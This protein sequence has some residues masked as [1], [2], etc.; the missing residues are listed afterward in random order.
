MA[1]PFTFVHAADLHLGTPFTGMGEVSPAFSAILRDATLAA[2]DNL[3]RLCLNEEAAFL[4]I[5]GDVWDGPGRSIRALS[6]FNEGVRKLGERGIPVF[7]S[8]GNHDPLGGRGWAAA[9]EMPPNLTVFPARKPTAVE[10]RRDGKLLAVVHG[11]SYHK[12]AV[13]DDLAARISRKNPDGFEVG[14][15]HATV[16]GG[17]GHEP[18]APTTVETLRASRLDYWALGHVHTRQVVCP[19]SPLACYPGNTQ[20]LSV[21][22]TGER[23]AFIVRVDE[24]GTPAAEFIALDAARFCDIRLDLSGMDQP[25]RIAELFRAALE[26]ERAGA[27][28]RALVAALKLTG[29]SPLYRDLGREGEIPELLALLREDIEGCE[30]PVWL[31][32]VENRLSPPL[33]LARIEASETLDGEAARQAKALL[34]GG[35]ALEEFFALLNAPL[36]AKPALRRLLEDGGALDAEEEFLAARDLALDLLA[37]DET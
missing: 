18:Y 27:E 24:A 3:A 8:A 34:E 23:G 28:G 17:A 21:R 9:G 6:R 22:E 7:V 30:P 19:E 31:D 20:A 1:T 26:R 10:V 36:S 12:E 14:V 5:A 2:F 25:S 11:M 15:L 32:R 33:E 16:G 13:T 37:G 4:V 29:R 35:P